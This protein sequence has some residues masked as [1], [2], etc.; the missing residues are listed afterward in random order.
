MVKPRKTVIGELLALLKGSSIGNA[1]K[2]MIPVNKIIFVSDS[3][4]NVERLSNDINKYPQRVAVH[5]Y[6][7]RNK[8]D[9]IQWI[10]GKRN[11]SDLLTRGASPEQ[12]MNIQQLDNELLKE[13]YH[14]LNECSSLTINISNQIKSDIIINQSLTY[15]QWIELTEQHINRITD[16]SLDPLT[17]LI[18]LNQQYFIDEIN[19]YP[20]LILDENSIIR[21]C[22]RLDNSDLD[23]NCKNPIYKHVSC[24]IMLTTT[25]HIIIVFNNN[26]TIFYQHCIF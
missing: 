2:S 24:Q 13:I 10:A 23:F 15:E 16:Q 8:I 12:L 11:P 18:R 21:C 17:M 9:A 25:T 4:A 5:L 1:F 6:N 14:E 22:T 20:N 7:I 19:K 26:N 3:K